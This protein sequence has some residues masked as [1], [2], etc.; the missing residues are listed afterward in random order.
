MEGTRLQPPAPS[1][2]KF[3]PETSVDSLVFSTSENDP[4]PCVSTTEDSL[5]M[6]VDLLTQRQD[7]DSLRRP[8]P[9]V[10]GGDLL[11]YPSWIKAFETFI[12]RKTKQ[13][14]E[15]LYYLGKF[16]S[17]EAKEAVSG[18]LPLEREEAYTLQGQ[19]NSSE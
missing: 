17:G 11:Q 8:Q 6:L 1:S 14:S 18:L 13:A 15:I 3:H 10:F 9:H 4:S 2:V 19:E 16:T 5:T 7:S 12:E